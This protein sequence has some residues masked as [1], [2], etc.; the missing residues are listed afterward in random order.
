MYGIMASCFEKE[1][2]R[3]E[4]DEYMDESVRKNISVWT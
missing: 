4:L 1:E 2:L 3:H